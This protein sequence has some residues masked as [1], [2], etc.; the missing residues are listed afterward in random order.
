MPVRPPGHVC[1][2]R[3]AAPRPARCGPGRR[4]RRLRVWPKQRTATSLGTST[5][6]LRCGRRLRPRRTPSPTTA[7]ARTSPT[8]CGKSRNTPTSS[9]PCIGTFVEHS[10]Q[11][12]LLFRH[13]GP[14]SADTAAW[15]SPPHSGSSA[16]PRP[17]LITPELPRELQTIA[18]AED[19]DHQVVGRGP[20]LTGLPGAVQKSRQWPSEMISTTPS[21]TLTAVSSSMA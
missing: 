15:T 8:G 4:Q 11:T 10:A 18:V 7:L 3:P 1:Q 21:A 2:R 17:L 16:S 12:V 20:A 14:T 9:H 5:L 13:P 6:N 19:E